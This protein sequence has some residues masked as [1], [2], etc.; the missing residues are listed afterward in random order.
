MTWSLLGVEFP[1][2]GRGKLYGCGELGAAV[3]TGRAIGEGWCQMFPDRN[4]GLTR[5]VAGRASAESSSA[6]S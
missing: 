2:S 5:R 3:G 4:A 6:I 1:S